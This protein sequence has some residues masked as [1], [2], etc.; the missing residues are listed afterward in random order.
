MVAVES[1]SESDDDV[2]AGQ[3]EEELGD[4]LSLYDTLEE[5]AEQQAAG[6]ASYSLHTFSK[7]FKT[8]LALY[9]AKNP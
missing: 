9:S 3:E 4:I 2:S 5:A 6:C 7:C 1:S 8:F